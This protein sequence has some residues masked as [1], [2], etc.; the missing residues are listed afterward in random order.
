MCGKIAAEFC[1]PGRRRTSLEALGLVRVG[2]DPTC[3]AQATQLFAKSLM[4]ELRPRAAVL[5]EVLLDTVR[6]QRCIS[7]P[8]GVNLSSEHIWGKDFVFSNLRFNLEGTPNPKQVRYAWKASQDKA[9]GR[10]YHNQRSWFLQRQ[11]GFDDPNATLALAFDAL[12]QA[13]LIILEPNRPGF[14]LDSRRLVF[15]DGREHSFHR[16]GACGLR[17]FANVED[18]CAAFRG[19]GTIEGITEEERARW[20]REQHYH[21]LYLAPTYAGK[22]ARE[23]TAAINNQLR[24]RLERQFRDGEVTVLSCS[25]TMELGVDIGELEAVVCRNV[26]PGIQNYQQRTGRAGRRTQ[27]APVSVTTAMSRNYDQ[28]EYR[29]AQEY[30]AQEPPTPFVHLENVRLF[31]RHQFSV[32]LRGLMQHLG[33]GE[34][35]GAS[36]QLSTFFGEDFPSRHRTL[37][38]IERWAPLPGRRRLTSRVVYPTR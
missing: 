4:V 24:E 21:R 3:L 12:K 35:Q 17:Q 34:G 16:C 29:R 20:K 32:L 33:L 5:L 22:V 6:R 31:R 18:C 36:P 30:L 37:A 9:S 7:A 1:L 14:V 8:P 15:T 27:A 28:A 11:L 2:Y 26:P 19:D 13:K 23:H 25:T 38:R 10:L